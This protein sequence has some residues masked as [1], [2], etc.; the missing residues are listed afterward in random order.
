LE[1]G[2]LEDGFLENKEKYT[3]LADNFYEGCVSNGA[4]EKLGSET[5]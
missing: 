2:I 5:E 1:P 3:K 4:A